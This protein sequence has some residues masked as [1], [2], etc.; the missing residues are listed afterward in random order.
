MA[1]S[2]R[3]RYAGAL[4]FIEPEPVTARQLC[5]AHEHHYVEAVLACRADTGFRNRLPEVAESLPWTCGAMLSAARA[6]LE[7]QTFTVAPVSG[8]HHASHEQGGGYCT[9]NGLMVAACSLREARPD[10]HVGI[11]DFD[12]HYGNGTADIIRCL[13]LDWVAHYSAASEWDRADQAERFLAQIPECMA[14]FAGCDLLLYQA[15]ADPH[16]NDPL[17]GWLTT[18]QLR[19]RDRQVFETARRMGLPLAWNLAGGYQEPL[20]RV[21]AIHDNTMLECLAVLAD[22]ARLEMPSAAAS[23]R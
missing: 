5:L 10:L 22:Q 1:D 23:V 7:Q 16:I 9:F 19:Q 17:G 6:A 15:G 11:L 12:Q 18:D 14:R 13:G 8:F 4:R 2:W 20:S 21:V 3:R